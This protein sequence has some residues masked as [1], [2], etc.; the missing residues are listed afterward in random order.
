MMRHENVLGFYGSDMIS[1]N[2]QTQLWLVTQYHRQGSLYD[3]LN[4]RSINEK[5]LLKF[6]YSIAN[7][8]AFLHSELV[9]TESRAGIA[10][11]DIKT[12]NILVSNSDVCVIAD[13]GLAVTHKRDTGELNV[14]ANPKVG[15]RRYMSP[16]ILDDSM[17]MKSFDAFKRADMYA[18]GLVLWELCRRTTYNG[19][20][21]EYQPPFFDV[22]PGDPSFEDMRKV[23]CVDGYR[24]DIPD[25]WC[26]DPVLSSITRLTKEC[27][28]PNPAVRLSAL[29]VK[30]SI[31]LNAQDKF[32]GLLDAAIVY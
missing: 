23:V 21:E 1:R 10:H 16:E 32:K 3:F 31:A 26:A 25:F 6:A 27:W 5:Q 14:F 12:K 2:S 30:K 19:L 7:G 13:F 17:N 22:V 24:P 4:N 29:R 18:F 28:H 9:G 8:L 20:C 15:T 11:R